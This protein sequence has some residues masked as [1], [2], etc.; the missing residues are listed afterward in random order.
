MT[1]YPLGVNTPSEM[2]GGLNAFTGVAKPVGP[3]QKPGPKALI[4][5]LQRNPGLDPA[6]IQQILAGIGGDIQAGRDERQQARTDLTSL[7]SG[8]AQQPGMTPD[9]LQALA[10]TSNPQLAQKPF[11]Q[12][13]LSSLGSALPGADTSVAPEDIA[14]IQES[15]ATLAADGES[16]LNDAIVATTQA[17]RL[18]GAPEAVIEKMK[19]YITSLW[20]RAKGWETFGAAPPTGIA[21]LAGSTGASSP[22]VLMDALRALP[23]NNPGE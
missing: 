5:W 14:A 23:L 15:V 2:S 17:A 10:T 19:Q 13:A 6:F 9:M 21:S 20:G 16:T 8:A 18:A 4:A 7:L 3:L 1:Q 12:T 22:N 11:A